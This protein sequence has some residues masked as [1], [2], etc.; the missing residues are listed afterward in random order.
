MAQKNL[1][2]SAFTLIELLVVIAIIAIL[3]ALLLPA[4]AAARE[5]ARRVACM[6]NLNQIG[7]AFVSYTGDYGGYVPAGQS[8]C[9]SPQVEYFDDWNAWEDANEYYTASR[10]GTA[11]ET[12]H[13]HQWQ[14]IGGSDKGE[15][16]RC[17]ASG[18]AFED[19]PGKQLKMAPRG[20]G[21][22]LVGGYL[23]DAGTFYCP[24]NA[25]LRYSSQGR[26]LQSGGLATSVMGPLGTPTYLGPFQTLGD[27]KLSGGRDGKALTH[28][29]WPDYYYTYAGP[30]HSY[31]KYNYRSILCHYNYRCIPIPVGYV[32]YNWFKKGRIPT[33]DTPVTVG[34]TKPLLS[35]TLNAPPLKTVRMLGARALACDS[36]ERLNNERTYDSDPVDGTDFAAAAQLLGASPDS[37]RLTELRGFGFYS[38]REGYNVLYGDGH[39]QWY[40]DPQ[41]RI[42]YWDHPD[43]VGVAGQTSYGGWGL[44]GWHSVGLMMQ[45]THYSTHYPIYEQ[46]PLLLWHQL[47]VAGEVDVDAPMGPYPG[48]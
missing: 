45:D 44:Q 25:A 40:G 22:L 11:S 20:L 5:K 17:L 33:V 37:A 12:I 38:H 48:S 46:G 1:L 15:Y 28:G 30:S 21:H 29:P 4:L 35:S 39:A 8:W 14:D 7:K 16:F 32:A 18:P 47:D 9:V 36:F 23:G 27:W 24:T 43:P 13:V 2:F 41:Q 6:N 31:Y 10:G 26:Y 34:Y 3:A 19:F 42:I